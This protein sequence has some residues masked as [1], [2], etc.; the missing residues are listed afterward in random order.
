M[1]PYLKARSANNVLTAVVFNC[2][3]LEFDVYTEQWPEV[4]LA[5]VPLPATVPA[6]SPGFEPAADE[7]GLSN[8]P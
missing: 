7:G 3:L 8:A 6:R 2:L 4:C 1:Q 5:L